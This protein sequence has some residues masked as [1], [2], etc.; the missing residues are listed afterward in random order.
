MNEYAIPVE[1]LLSVLLGQLSR[2]SEVQLI[3]ELP[4]LQNEI[5]SPNS[6]NMTHVRLCSRRVR[7]V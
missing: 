4:A 1:M 5:T 6:L 3:Q 2:F 7:P